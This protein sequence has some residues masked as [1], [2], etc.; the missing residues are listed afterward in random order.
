MSGRFASSWDAARLL[1][2]LYGLRCG[3]SA[4]RAVGVVAAAGVLAVTVAQ[5]APA[6]AAGSRPSSPSRFL[7]HA[8]HEGAHRGVARREMVPGP[9]LSEA[10]VVAARLPGQDLNDHG[11]LSQGGFAEADSWQIVQRLVTL[12]PG[13][14]LVAIAAKTEG[15]RFGAT[16]LYTL[17]LAAKT[18][19]VVFEPVT[20]SDTYLPEEYVRKSFPKIFTKVI[21]TYRVSSPPLAQTSR[22]GPRAQAI[23]D[24]GFRGDNPKLIFYHLT[25]NPKSTYTAEE[26]KSALG[27]KSISTVHTAL[28][29]LE[30]IQVIHKISSRASGRVLTYQGKSE[31]ELR[32]SNY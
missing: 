18:R 3:V 30:D 8:S 21:D 31:E 28:K 12:G 4:C 22:L 14:R 24:H 25:T 9:G 6:I 15:D 23:Y 10:H 32:A 16:G 7:T 29:R 13:Q 11:V 2:C 26:L 19:R 1:L 27:F 17:S 20:P 5:A